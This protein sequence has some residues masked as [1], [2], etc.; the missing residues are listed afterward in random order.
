MKRLFLFLLT[1]IGLYAQNQNVTVQPSPGSG[2]MNTGTFNTY[3]INYYLAKPATTWDFTQATVLLPQ[4]ISGVLSI[5][6]GP[7]IGVNNNTGQ[8]TVSNLGVITLTAGNGLVGTSTAGNITLNNVGVLGVQA[9][10]GI[11]ITG[12]GSYPII[13]SV[14]TTNGTVTSVSAIGQNGIGAVTT[15]SSTTPVLSLI[16]I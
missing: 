16:H 10:T 8:V 13:N 15:N 14:S 2:G 3:G 4:S 7:G 12:N 9:G 11:S 6:A 1:A 5:N